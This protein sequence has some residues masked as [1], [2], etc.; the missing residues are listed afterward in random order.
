[1]NVRKWGKEQPRV[2]TG[3]GRNPAEKETHSQL[4]Y[5]GLKGK[6]LLKKH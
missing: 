5:P 1:M 4:I 2:C 6:E 3:G